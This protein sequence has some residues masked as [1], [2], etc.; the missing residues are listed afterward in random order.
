[1]SKQPPP[2][3]CTI[4]GATKPAT[5]FHADSRF[6]GGRRA[7]CAECTNARTRAR[8]ARKRQEGNKPER[9]RDERTRF[10]GYP[11]CRSCWVVM[12]PDGDIDNRPWEHDETLCESCGRKGVEGKRG[13]LTAKL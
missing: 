7:S 3:T 6:V 4:C 13:K 9:V 5:S 8:E 2:K 11:H 10:A 12:F 1:M